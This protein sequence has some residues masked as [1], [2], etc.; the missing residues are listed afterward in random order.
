MHNLPAQ[1]EYSF[2]LV[3]F[4]KFLK[5]ANIYAESNA[6]LKVCNPYL[7]ESYN[8]KRWNTILDHSDFERTVKES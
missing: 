3:E 7:M 8:Q 6:C 1:N 2:E 5:K 4:F